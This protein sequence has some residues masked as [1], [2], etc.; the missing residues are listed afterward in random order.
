M[1]SCERCWRDSRWAEFSGG[2]ASDEYRRLLA[3]RDCSAE[4]QAGDDAYFCADCAR[5]TAHQIC[6]RCV[7]CGK[8]PTVLVRRDDASD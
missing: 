5:W 4:Q 3:E 8:I 7:V 6:Y 1:P 2:N